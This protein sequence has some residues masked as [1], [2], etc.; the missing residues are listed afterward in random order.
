MGTFAQEIN[1]YVNRGT[2]VLLPN[3]KSEY[4][5][6][7]PVMYTLGNEQTWLCLK[8]ILIIRFIMCCNDAVRA[9]CVDKKCPFKESSVAGHERLGPVVLQEMELQEIQ[10]GIQSL[11]SYKDLPEK[12][13]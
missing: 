9:G 8:L 6:N 10:A 2:Q 11:E 12:D 13:K 5:H 7:A 1:I 3:D 4:R